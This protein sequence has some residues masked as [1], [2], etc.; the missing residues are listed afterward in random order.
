VT[1]YEIEKLVGFVKEE[2]FLCYYS[3]DLFDEVKRLRTFNLV[4]NHDGV[5]LSDLRRD[6]K[7]KDKKFDLKQFL[8]VTDYGREYLKLRAELMQHETLEQ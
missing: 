3:D 6:Y 5:R 8:F 4:K 2:P 1:K 7:D